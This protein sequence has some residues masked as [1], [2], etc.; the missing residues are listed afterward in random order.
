MRTATIGRA[1]TLSSHERSRLKTRA[2]SLEPVVRIGRTGVT[3][4]LVA[5]VDRARTDQGE[6]LRWMAET[7]AARSATRSPNGSTALP[8]IALER[9]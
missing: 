9:S 1:G 2:H 4:E 7:S 8:F 5:E 6:H 3:P